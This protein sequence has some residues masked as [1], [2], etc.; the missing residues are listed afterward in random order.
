MAAG[1]SPDWAKNQS[2][3][4]AFVVLES[5]QEHLGITEFSL[6]QTTLEQVFLRITSDSDHH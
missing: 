1:F 2:V 3:G 5:V 6:S 4:L